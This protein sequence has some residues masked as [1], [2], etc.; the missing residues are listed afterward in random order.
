MILIATIT[1]FLNIVSILVLALGLFHNFENPKNKA[2]SGYSIAASNIPFLMLLT[3]LI[4]LEI[5]NGHYI[6]SF[7]FLCVISPFIIGK[8]VRY[9]T[10]KKYTLIQVFCFIINAILLLRYYF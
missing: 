7:L 3:I 8:L 1:L 2:I 4:I 6:L 10:L 5:L 9:E